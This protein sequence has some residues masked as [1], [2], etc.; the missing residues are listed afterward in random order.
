MEH[1]HYVA[2]DISVHNFKTDNDCAKSFDFSKDLL[3]HVEPVVA[4]GEQIWK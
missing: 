2:D 3:R 4:I 1:I